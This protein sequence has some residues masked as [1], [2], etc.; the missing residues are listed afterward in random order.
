MRNS[1]LRYLVDSLSGSPTSPCQVTSG[2]HI[3]DGRVD[4]QFLG[5]HVP[6]TLYPPT[7]PCPPSQYIN[8]TVFIVII[9]IFIHLLITVI[10][11]GI[12]KVI[13]FQAP[14]CQDELPRGRNRASD[15]S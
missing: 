2:F 7:H 15:Q 12:V 10:I 11:I 5:G 14:Q 8:V 4:P 6:G 1:L 9:P 3:S 13:P